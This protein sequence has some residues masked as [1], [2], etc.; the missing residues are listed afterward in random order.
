MMQYNP[1]FIIIGIF[2]AIV[3]YILHRRLELSLNL[4]RNET[5]NY[6][7]QLDLKN[8]EEIAIGR[9]TRIQPFFGRVFYGKG[10]KV[11][12]IY[13]KLYDQNDQNILTLFYTKGIIHDAPEDFFELSELDI[14]RADKGQNIF[15]CS[16]FQEIFNEIRKDTGIKVSEVG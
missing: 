6:S 8:G 14:L 3:W 12:E 1:L 9:I 7:I 15:Y 13:L 16:N 2:F 4:F 5:G 10:P 11:K